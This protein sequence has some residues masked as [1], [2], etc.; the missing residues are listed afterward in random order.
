MSLLQDLRTRAVASYVFRGVAHR[1]LNL[2]SQEPPNSIVSISFPTPHPRLWQMTAA[3]DF[4]PLDR[5]VNGPHPRGDHF[6]L[7]QMVCCI[8][9]QRACPLK[10]GTG[11]LIFVIVQNFNQGRTVQRTV[12]FKIRASLLLGT[13]GRDSSASKVTGWIWT[14]G[15]RF[16]QMQ[17]SS[18]MLPSPD[19]PRTHG[20]SLPFDTRRPFVPGKT[21]GMRS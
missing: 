8:W 18:S 19:W 6:H 1:K 12:L 11:K 5:Y 10:H 16:Q 2:A 17:S 13:M 4:R 7:R 9:K 21:S 3:A 14:A 20:T 15:V